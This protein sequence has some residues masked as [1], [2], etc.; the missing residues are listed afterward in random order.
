RLLHAP[1][2]KKDIRSR[3][4]VLGWRS[5]QSR[6]HAPLPQK[7]IRSR[8]LK[9]Y[10]D[11]SGSP[12][13]WWTETVRLWSAAPPAARMY[14]SPLML[15][16]IH[17]CVRRHKRLRKTY[18]RFLARAGV[19]GFAAATRSFAPLLD[20]LHQEVAIDP[21]R[22]ILEAARYG[23]PVVSSAACFLPC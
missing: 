18:E 14:L 2:T 1:L 15:E 19:D 8:K 6:R 10:A 9:K 11:G 17:H 21:L 13:E 22:T 7:D 23:Y 16:C 20:H 5:S 12:S 3:S 4:Q